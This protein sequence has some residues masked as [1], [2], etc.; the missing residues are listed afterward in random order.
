MPSNSSFHPG[1]LKVQQLAGTRGVADE[2]S[3]A[4]S[5]T[6]PVGGSLDSL[7]SNLRM[8]V[9]SSVSPST[10]VRDSSVWVSLLFGHNF[11]SAPDPAQLKI[12]LRGL[13]PHDILRQ[14]LAGPS[15]NPVGILALDFVKRRRY[16]TNGT[17]SPFPQVG[18]STQRELPPVLNISILEAFPNC[19]KYIQIR[20]VRPETSAL[21]PVT[22]DGVMEIDNKLC[23][24]DK[25]LISAAD[26]LFLGS[27]YKPTGA[28]V[29]HRGGQP[30]FVRVHSDTEIYWPDYRGNGMFQS[31]GNLQ[32][33]KQ[34]GL[35]LVSF[36]TGE[37]LQLSGT[38]VVEWKVDKALNIEAAA[39]RVVR[40]RI[41][42]IRRSVGAATNYRWGIP[43]YSPYNPNVLGRNENHQSGTNGFPMNVTLVKIVKESP[44]VKTFRFL[45]PRYLKFLPGQYATFDFGQV[46]SLA[47]EKSEIVRTWTLSET[48]NSVKGDV[49][50]EVSVKRKKGGLISNWLHDSATTGLQV[51][52][53]GFGGYMTPFSESTPLPEKML[54]ISGGI[55]ITPNMAILRGLGAR[56]GQYQTKPDVVFIHQE[57]NEEDI[58]FK[59]ELHRRANDG[60]GATKLITLISGKGS[61]GKKIFIG[62][63][64]SR[65]ITLRGRISMEVLRNCVS[66]VQSRVVFL[67]GPAVFMNQVTGYLLSVGVKGDN[68]ITEAFNF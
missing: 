1:E 66:D 39:E 45:A 54:F 25:D 30:G 60:G 8:I 35:A 36:E 20:D 52:L 50:L 14:N 40:F 10:P 47:N 11:V 43:E 42:K 65:A 24:A 62:E 38:A 17:V 2:L 57:R 34:A 6:L 33:N 58:P 26:T 22:L 15:E 23:Q 61:I 7:L 18:Q 44:V 4:L 49:T 63:D 5:D 3:A 64:E 67:C 48:A 21:S 19:P 29:N 41:E 13:A 32:L 59:S 51:Q 28:D 55:G 31:F 37:V 68:I 46:P 56:S 16:R 53:L 9:L 27:F 12:D